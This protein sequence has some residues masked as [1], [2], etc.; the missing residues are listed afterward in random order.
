MSAQGAGARPLD[1]TG[2]AAQPQKEQEGAQGNAAASPLQEP[3]EGGP[4][5]GRPETL[6]PGSS[7]EEDAPAPAAPAPT[8]EEAA[9]RKRRREQWEAEQEGSRRWDLARRLAAISTDVEF[10]AREVG[11]AQAAWGAGVDG[12]GLFKGVL[13]V[14]G[15]CHCMGMFAASPAQHGHRLHLK[16]IA[17]GRNTSRLPAASQL[18]AL[19]HTS[20]CQ[21]EICAA[22][23]AACA[24]CTLPA[25][26]SPSWPDGGRLPGLAGG[27]GAG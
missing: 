25:H 1:A 21:L 17:P 8:A 26:R 12:C 16:R 23:A 3:S 27:A 6:L 19:S 10:L 15:R 18:R 2:A 24:S 4:P 11:A 20:C 9:R 14:A 13:E 22:A 5:L 7:E